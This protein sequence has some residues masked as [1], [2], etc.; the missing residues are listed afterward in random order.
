MKTCKNDHVACSCFIIVVFICCILQNFWQDQ[1]LPLHRLLLSRRESVIIPVLLIILTNDE[2]ITPAYVTDHLQVHQLIHTKSYCI[3]LHNDLKDSLCIDDIDE[4]VGC[5][6]MFT[7]LCT[8]RWHRHFK[9]L[10]PRKN[11]K[12]EIHI[13]LFIRKSYAILQK[14]A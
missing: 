5:L 1:M 14:T 12:F 9:G 13:F 10:V 2:T 7:V 6:R 4:K 8:V 3:V 11:Q